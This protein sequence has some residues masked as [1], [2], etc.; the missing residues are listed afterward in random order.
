MSNLD[1]IK[2]AVSALPHSNFEWDMAS[3]HKPGAVNLDD[4]DMQWWEQINSD[5]TE[6]SSGFDDFEVGDLIEIL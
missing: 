2:Q 1:K 3:S 6:C 4:V 5:A